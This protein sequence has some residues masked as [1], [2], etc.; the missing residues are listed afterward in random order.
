[1][2]TTVLWLLI[3]ACAPCSAQSETDYEHQLRVLTKN[4]EQLQKE[5]SKTKSSRDKLQQSLQNSEEEI[6]ALQNKITDIKETLAREKKQLAQ[7]QS[8]RTEL[9]ISRKR[10]QR[11]ISQILRQAYVLGQQ[12]QIKLLLNQ[13]AP[14]R[15][16]R[17]LR[18]HDY[19]VSAHRQKLASYLEILE[20][21]SIVEKNITT[22]LEKL[23]TNRNRLNQRF[24]ELKNTQAKRLQTLAKINGELK[25]KGDSLN[26]LQID[27]E[28]LERLLEKA[29]QAL[30]QLKLPEGAVDFHRVR[31]KLPYPTNGR[32]THSYGSPRLKGKLRWQGLFIRGE[33]GDDVVSV[34]HGR[35][36]FSDYLRGHGLLLIIDHG[37]EYMSLYA[38][39]QTLLKETGEWVSRGEPIAKLGNTGGQPHA[40]LY[41][42][43][44]HQG[45]PQNPKPWLKRN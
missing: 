42:E 43:I 32:I 9:D 37:D 2:I 15:V 7:L 40:G 5:L 41:F 1:M 30:S 17:L 13:E 45:K 4:I 19:I 11:Q 10:Q 44:R 6:S 38:H 3:I 14:Q 26:Q 39:N 27:Q 28:R 25:S 35:V 33:A 20:D 22:T 12:S 29:T 23:D 18:Y 8:R 31:G 24:R 36:I 34:H 21:I 16:T